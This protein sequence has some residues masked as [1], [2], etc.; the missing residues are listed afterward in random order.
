MMTLDI[1]QDARKGTPDE[2]GQ[3]LRPTRFNP[4]Y[5]LTPDDVKLTPADPMINQRIPHAYEQSLKKL[6]AKP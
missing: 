1:E 6:L 5:T 4:A 3:T 2:T